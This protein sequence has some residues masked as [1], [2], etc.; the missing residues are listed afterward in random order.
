MSVQILHGQPIEQPA[1]QPARDLWQAVR[2]GMMCRCPACG[3]GHLFTSYLKVAPA[4]DHC[5]EVLSHHRADDAPPYLTIMVVGHIVVPMLM[6]LELRYQPELWIHFVLWLP[7]TLIMSLA[8]L[9]PIKGAVVGYQ[10]A[11]RMHGFDE[12]SAEADE[13]RKL[14][15]PAKAVIPA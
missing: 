4:C 15:N 9:P 10:W 2:R 12:H 5:G 3:Q 8:M 14:A 11:L 7:L 6:W 1:E 13:D